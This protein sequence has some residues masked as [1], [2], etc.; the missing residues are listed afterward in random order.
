MLQ[1]RPVH[2]VPKE[3]KEAPESRDSL[4]LQVLLARKALKGL[5]VSLVSRALQVRRVR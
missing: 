3:F 1:V 4:V 2:R 5:L